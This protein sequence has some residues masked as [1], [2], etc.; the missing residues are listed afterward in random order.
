[1]FGEKKS[2]S[3]PVAM[4]GIFSVDQGLIAYNLKE[5]HFKVEHIEE[6]L[7]GFKGIIE[8]EVLGNVKDWVIVLDNLSAHHSK[9]LDEMR[10]QLSNLWVEFLF[11]PP[12]TPNFNVIESYWWILK[13]EFYKDWTWQGTANLKGT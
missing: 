2:T 8:S 6:F 1:M 3:L 10:N 7:E 13:A 11:M 4:I 5:G 12:Y 9:R